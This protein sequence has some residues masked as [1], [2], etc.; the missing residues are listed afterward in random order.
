MPEPR[1]THEH[2]YTCEEVVEL[3][4]EYVEG[5]MGPEETTLFEFHLNFCDGCET[6]VDQIRASAGAAGRL[7]A[8]DVPADVRERLLEAF[9]E[10]R[11]S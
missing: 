8:E 4:T 5:A 11:R 6:F 7:G 10:W 1:G 9:R 3:A 2:N